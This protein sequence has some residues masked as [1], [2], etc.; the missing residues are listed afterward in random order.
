M[1]GDIVCDLNLFK[2]LDYHFINQASFTILCEKV[3]KQPKP[4]TQTEVKLKPF[5]K[6]HGSDKFVHVL[7]KH[8]NR[9]LG[10]IDPFDLKRGIQ[11]KTAILARHPKIVFRSDLQGRGIV[12]CSIN[13]C[14]I[15]SKVGHNL[16]D[17]FEDFVSFVTYNQYNKNLHK[18]ITD[19]QD[20]QSDYERTFRRFFQNDS[21]LFRPFIY[22]TNENIR[23]SQLTAVASSTSTTTTR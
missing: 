4:S 19:E 2:L 23:Y 22:I 16:H 21:D 8:T 18:I 10:F 11:M 20:A 12:V 15:L 3:E 6:D 7:D 13:I 9:L 5:Q 1:M 14:K 17:F